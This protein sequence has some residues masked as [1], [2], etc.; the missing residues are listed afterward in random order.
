VQQVQIT[1]VSDVILCRRLSSLECVTSSLTYA[2]TVS[3]AVADAQYYLAGYVWQ[4]SR[5]KS[6]IICYI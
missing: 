5:I 1:T 4:I 2:C 6:H 3:L